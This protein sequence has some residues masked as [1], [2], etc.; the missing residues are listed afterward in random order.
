MDGKTSY[1]RR[2]RQNIAISACVE[3]LSGKTALNSVRF[4]SRVPPLFGAWQIIRTGHDGLAL[5]ARGA[6]RAGRGTL[7]FG[8]AIPAILSKGKGPEKAGGDSGALSAWF[9][10]AS[11]QSTP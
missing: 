5:F 4:A 8:S 11:G 10:E 1:L 2:S 3:L 6:D 9:H 7:R